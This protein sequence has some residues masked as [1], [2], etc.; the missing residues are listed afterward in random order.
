VSAP[1]RLDAAART[2]AGTADPVLTVSGLRVEYVH[3][4]R[5][6]PAVKGVDL[7]VGPGET[8][9]LVGESGS[10]K[11]TTAHAVIGLLPP[12]ARQTAD[13]VL[14]GSTDVRGWS[15]RR[16]A[17][18][19]GRYVGFVP[20][21]PGVA[22]NPVQRI[23]TQVTEALR[24]HRLVRPADAPRRAVE[25]LAAAGM[26]DPEA[27]A[28]R[29]PHELSGGQRQRVLIGIALSADP[30]LVIAD[31]PTSALDVTVQRV[32]L[33]H[34]AERTRT[35]GASVLLITHDL[36]VAADRADRVVV[37]RAGE[38]VEQGPAAQVLTDPRHEYTRRL[39]AAAPS[40]RSSRIVATTRAD[41]SSAS[42]VSR[43]GRDTDGDRHPVVLSLQ[44]VEK[45]F[46]SR[47]RGVTRT[48]DAVAGVSLQVRRG[49]TTALVGAS[50]SGKTTVARIAARL[51]AADAGRIELNG[52]DI[53]AARGNALREL[54]R[55]LQLVY[56]DPFG[57]LN[58][59]MRI[60]EIV[61]A[62]LRAYGIGTR[63][64]RR[65]RAADL[66]HRVAIPS[67][68]HD[69]LPTELSGGQRQR[70]AIARAIALE[71]SLLIL[72][73]PV[74]AL[75]VSVQEQL[76]RLLADLQAERG[77]GY[78][79]ITHDLAVVR[80]IADDVAVMNEGLVV[81]EGRV[82]DIFARPAH[83]YTRQLLD[84]IPGRRTP[85]PRDINPRNRQGES[86]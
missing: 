74:S 14:L 67:E 54:R 11:T 73:E 46:S 42:D 6:V 37:M 40:L 84:A 36:G 59:R 71:P 15:Q 60:A 7:V 5:S 47:A 50:G 77:L 35:L 45:R 2:V 1:I 61:A 58:P 83:P 49:A 10:G 26:D 30:A 52:T 32:I 79:F 22:L 48:V 34:L 68:L 43:A 16:F 17:S 28:H 55:D 64:T 18:V 76:L 44:G 62:P 53:T 80:Q 56:Q 31:E 3:R 21:D 9:A 24:I 39:V 20:Q 41:A 72:D 25:I 19:R 85:V 63:A 78:L 33:D 57:S 70:V 65:S 86:A 12:A 27:V 8:V 13:A 81:E 38:V 23:G 29:Y 51:V 4:G 66:L 69:R 75:D 82:D